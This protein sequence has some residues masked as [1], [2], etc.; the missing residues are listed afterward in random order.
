[1]LE[2][3]QGLLAATGKPP[4]GGVGG[5][6][7]GGCGGGGGGGGGLGQ[8]KGLWLKGAGGEKL[9]IQNKPL[10]PERGIA[11]PPAMVGLVKQYVLTFGGRKGK[12]GISAKKKV[13]EAPARKGASS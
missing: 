11:A 2:A 7:G 6:G 9:S 5:G 13:R 1:L 8:K 12:G 3:S 10:P 4:G